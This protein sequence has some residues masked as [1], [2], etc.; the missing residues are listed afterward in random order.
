MAVAERRVSFDFDGVGADALYELG[1]SADDDIVGS[2]VWRDPFQILGYA[3]AGRQDGAVRVFDD[4][5]CAFDVAQLNL[6][7]IFDAAFG[8]E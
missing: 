6:D 5:G 3:I 2:G 8:R 4:D 1:G 7:A